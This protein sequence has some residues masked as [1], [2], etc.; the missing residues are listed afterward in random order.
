MWDQRDVFPLEVHC[1]S[2]DGMVSSMMTWKL[3][4]S[5]AQI[6]IIQ[7][8]S[9]YPLR[10]KSHTSCNTSC[11]GILCRGICGGKLK[12][13]CGTCVWWFAFIWSQLQ[14][15]V[16]SNGFRR[17]CHLVYL[18][19]PKKFLP[20]WIL[21]W[22]YP[23]EFSF[24]CSIEYAVYHNIPYGFLMNDSHSSIDPFWTT[25]VEFCRY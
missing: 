20:C 19:T 18:L 16:K 1:K 6:I 17:P 24:E 15:S 21:F 25:G 11:T 23:V 3:A 7:S 2:F 4:I 5:D 9:I 8:Q 13:G 22:L 14:L 10:K 12:V